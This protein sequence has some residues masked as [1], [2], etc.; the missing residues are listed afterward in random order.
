MQMD[1]GLH[2]IPFLCQFHAGKNRFDY[3][4]KVPGDDSNNSAYSYYCHG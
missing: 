1:I 2:D 3:G 4:D